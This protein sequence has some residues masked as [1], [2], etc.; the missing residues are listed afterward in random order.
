[1]ADLPGLIEGAHMN[2]GMGHKFLKHVERTKMLLFIVDVFGFRL[3]PQYPLRSSFENVLLLNRVGNL[4][5][6]RF[7]LIFLLIV[8]ISWFI[9]D[10]T[11]L[12]YFG[13]N[14]N[15]VSLY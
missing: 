4:R 3:N 15:L 5:R 6:D 14:L 11:L 2:V 9:L 8:Y 10:F 1:M 12:I 13:F 7:Y